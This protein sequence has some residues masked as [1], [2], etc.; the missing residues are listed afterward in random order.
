MDKRQTPHNSA[1]GTHAAIMK[2][3]LPILGAFA[4][5]S[6]A[7]LTKPEPTMERE[8]YGTL[9]DGREAGIF[10]LRN[11]DGLV[12]KVTEYGAILVSLE[13][14][15]RDGR[16]ADVTLGYDTLDGWLTNSSY[17]G[18]TVG[19]Y[20]NRIADGKFTL[21][22]QTH[23]LATNNAPGG[24]PCHLHGGVKGFDKVLWK[25][26][27]VEKPGACGV[28]FTYV[29]KDGEE[30]YPGAL[31]ARVT[32][33]LTSD[34]ELVWEA[35]ATTDKATPV[36]IVHH[37]YWNLTGDPRRTIT[38][39]LLTLEADRYLP[40]TAGLIPTGELAPVAGTP[41]D[42]TKPMRIGE[43]IDADFEALKLG[44][45]YDHCWVLNSGGGRLARAA[46][47]EDPATGRVMEI[48]TDQPGIQFYSG[49]F[50]DGSVRGK[51]GLAYA[52]RTGLC[53][54][55]QV[56][57]NSPNEAGF[58]DAILRPGETYRH[59]MAHKFTTN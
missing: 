46:R 44:G 40:T 19:R 41:M 23:T 25:G 29:S 34:N 17:F 26:T 43:R 24:I 58:P 51:D 18:S 38:D 49:N 11:A 59:R 39:H 12:A 3:C 54:E 35:E 16:T 32:Y 57:P 45:G 53:L 36:N 21:D 15:D 2:Y 9:P 56:F 33:W 7:T 27:P 20:G 42:F 50:L 5:A 14:P 22:G 8:V 31:Q 6:C 47:L 52:Y 30:G 28:Q 55:T 37:S 13:V 4:L 48:F 10:T 1:G